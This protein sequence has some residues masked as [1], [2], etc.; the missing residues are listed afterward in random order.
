MHRLMKEAARWRDGTAVAQPELKKKKKK[1][2]FQV[3]APCLD[4]SYW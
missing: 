1:D 4:T 2:G 3:P